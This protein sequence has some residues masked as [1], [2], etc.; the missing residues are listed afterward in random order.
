LSQ[1][2]FL[3]SEPH[4]QPSIT[5]PLLPVGPGTTAPPYISAAFQGLWHYFGKYQR[6]QGKT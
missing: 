2:S 5:L 1:L 3:P 4:V 6:G